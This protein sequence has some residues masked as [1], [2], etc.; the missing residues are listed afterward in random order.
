[1]GERSWARL[2]IGGQVPRRLLTDALETLAGCRL[3]ECL[4]DGRVVVEDPEASWGGFSELEAWLEGRGIPF[5]LESA[6][7][8]G[9][10][11]DMLVHF[12][13]GRGRVEFVADDSH[14]EPV[15][16]RSTLRTALR[17]YRTLK[18]LR[19]WLARTYPEVPALEPI[20]WARADPVD[21]RLMDQVARSG[22]CATFI[23]RDLGDAN[24][25]RHRS[26]ESHL[27][28]PERTRMVR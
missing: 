16:P 25:E 28:L 22:T 20:T 15:I 10:W 4:E 21:D 8:P 19:A 18:S 1:M 9:A 24:T 7:C 13:P 3:D 6:A 26:A 27:R 5:D 23:P 2:T 12:R 17:R 11:P 14:A